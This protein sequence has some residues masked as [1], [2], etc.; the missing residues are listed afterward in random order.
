M[1]ALSLLILAGC[2][3]APPPRLATTDLDGDACPTAEEHASLGLGGAAVY[4]EMRSISLRGLSDDDAFSVVAED[5]PAVL[6]RYE[7]VVGRG[8]AADWATACLYAHYANLGASLSA[9]PSWPPDVQEAW[10]EVVRTELDPIFASIRGKALARVERALGADPD[11]AW[12]A[13][14]TALRE[15]LR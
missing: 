12:A 5:V 13:R 1:R 4:D 9:D 2:P 15:S 11:A 10:V 6:A 7:A 8:P 14:A 3:K